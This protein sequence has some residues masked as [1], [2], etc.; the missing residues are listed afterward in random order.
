MPEDT[1]TQELVKL[2]DLAPKMGLEGVVTRT[3]LYGAFVNI[4]AEREGLVHISRMANKRVNKV[5]DKVSVG[6]TIHVWVTDVDAANGR[7]GLTMVEPPEVDWRELEVGEIRKGRVVRVERYGAFVDIGAE[8]PGLV[9]ISEMGRYVKDPNDVVRNNQEV[10][11]RIK[12]LNRQKRQIDLTLDVEDETVIEDDDAPA[13]LSPMEIAFRQAQ[14][15]NH[16]SN[17]RGRKGNSKKTSRRHSE[18]DDLEDI[19]RRTLNR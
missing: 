19:Y 4:G 17:K 13:M 11:V 1:T 12:G 16:A 8:R 15:Q 2:E 14:Q 9:H 7:I 10:E 18:E 3:E 5:T 6:D